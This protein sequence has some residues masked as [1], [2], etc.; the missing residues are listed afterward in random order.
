[1]RF[2]PSENRITIL[3]FRGARLHY[4][5]LACNGTGGCGMMYVL[6]MVRSSTIEVVEASVLVG[7]IS[8]FSSVRLTRYF[9][10]RYF[11][12]FSVF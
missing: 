5:V 3:E 7:R 2:F 6:A 8:K 10:A 11:C 1:M 9:S 4:L 12:S